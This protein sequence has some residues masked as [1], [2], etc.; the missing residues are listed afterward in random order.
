MKKKQKEKD[1]K[2]ICPES[3]TDIENIVEMLQEKETSILVDMS[4]C[5][6]LN[7]NIIKR[8]MEFISINQKTYMKL[9]VKKIF[10]KVLVCWSERPKLYI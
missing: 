8:I 3:S 7:K 1:Y 5:R 9:N 4:K 6:H 2:V 10:P